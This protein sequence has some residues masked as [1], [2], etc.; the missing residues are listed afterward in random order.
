MSP[1]HHAHG[2]NRIARP[3]HTGFNLGQTDTKNGLLSM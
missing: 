2:E 3:V 1:R